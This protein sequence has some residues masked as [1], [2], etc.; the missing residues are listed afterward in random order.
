[1]ISVADYVVDRVDI[2][3]GLLED[4]AFNL[5]FQDAP[6]RFI[7]A[8]LGDLTGLHGGTNTCKRGIHIRGVEQNIGAGLN[9][10]D[11]Y[12]LL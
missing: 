12:L 2:R 9:G 1:M 10:H 4:S 7:E 5:P 11:R 8:V 6:D 3:H